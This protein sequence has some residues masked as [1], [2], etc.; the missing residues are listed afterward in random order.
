M[1]KTET[2]K[3]LPKL[4]VRTLDPNELSQV[5]GGLP[6]REGGTSGTVSFCHIDGTDDGDG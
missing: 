2:N 6:P 1:K 4:K 3:A 5:T